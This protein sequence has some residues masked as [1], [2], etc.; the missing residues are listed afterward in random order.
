MDDK[1]PLGI[2]GLLP[3]EDLKRNT[4]HRITNAE[5]KRIADTL[6][7]LLKISEMRP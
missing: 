2:S 1:H 7:R 3:P 5:L 6:E 4:L